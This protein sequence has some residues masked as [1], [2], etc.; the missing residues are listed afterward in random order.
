MAS[1]AVD[2]YVL[3]QIIKRISTPFEDTDA[4]KLGLIDKKGKRLKKASTS[5]EKKAMTYF[6]RFVFNIKRVMG[7][8]GLDTRVGTYAAALFLLKESDK[9]GMP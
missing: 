2:L 7:K 4:Y 5:E 3:Y 8:V 9:P 6:D 1:Q